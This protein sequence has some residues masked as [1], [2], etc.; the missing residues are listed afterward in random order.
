MLRSLCP[1][2]TKNEQMRAIT[3]MAP[4]C[5][6]SA[7]GG[8][9]NVFKSACV[10]V[11]D[12]NAVSID[13][14]RKPAARSANKDWLR[15]LQ[16]TASIEARPDRILPVRFDDVVADRGAAIA[17][18]DER[19][20]LTFQEFAARANRFSRWALASDLQKGDVV[21][22][23]MGNCAD[24][25][26]IWLGLTRV[27]VVVALLNT[28]LS[29]PALAHCLRAAAARHIIAGDAFRSLCEE[30]GPLLDA[31]PRLHFLGEAGFAGLSG[32]PLAATET[33]EVALKDRALYIYTS[34]TTGLPKAA[35]VTHR[36][37]LYW[38]LWFSGLADIDASDRM[39]DCLP[40]YHSV[41]GV[42]AIWS[43]LLSGA[44]V[45]LRAR[46][47]ASN[48]WADIATTR[49]TLFQYIGEL[50]RYLLNAPYGEAQH[51]HILRLALGNGLRADVWEP[52]QNRF[53]IPRILEFYAATESNFSLYNVEGEPGA[54]GRIPAFLAASQ[55]I[56]LV[57][58]DD[59][60]GLPARGE[61]GRCFRCEANEAGE[62]IAR[63]EHE[64]GTG[65]FDGYVSRA[66]SDK[67]VLRDVFAPGDAWM[68]SGDLM[69]R[70]ARG[71]FYFADRIGDSFRW[72]G[73][74]VSTFEVAE[75]LASCPGVRDATVY[76][77]AVPGHEGRAGMAALVVETGFDLEALRSYVERALPPYARP[78]F[79]RLSETLEITETFKHKK[80]ALCAQGFDP[81]Q[82]EDGL[83]FAPP[84]AGYVALDDATYQRICGGEFR[85]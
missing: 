79:L 14:N 69:R 45:V 65:V 78:L 4:D 83:Y 82:I 3:L 34:G 80:Q 31:P 85:L 32:A 76:G 68:R 57:R 53:T 70:D 29:A 25:A 58:F 51:N 20:S 28:H 11:D 81:A 15:A 42:V 54:I 67:K 21:A 33:R 5:I 12:M 61:D 7:P 2:L 84:G 48:F 74:N 44:S 26:A 62:A 63:I 17:V 55:Q 23:L 50:C 10:G 13:T 41:G 37:L 18:I 73:E 71:F 36:R 75:T 77:V 39:Y 43:A 22:L 24:Y 52:F 38:S 56:A 46:F 49:C 60:L 30:A 59:E 40:M 72:K 9:R 35:I 19:E 16:R 66:D 47:S 27:G 6:G 64:E 8:L 1:S